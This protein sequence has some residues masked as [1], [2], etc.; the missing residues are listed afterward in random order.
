M[1]KSYSVGKNYPY[2]MSVCEAG[3]QF[4]FACS[5][6]GNLVLKVYNENGRLIHTINMLQYRVIGNVYS[7]IVSGLKYREISYEY[8]ADGRIVTDPY[9]MKSKK[10]HKWGDFEACID[11]DK[12]MLYVDDFDWEGDVPLKIPYNEVIGYLLHVRGFTKHPSSKV[13][14]KGTFLGIV[15][16]ITYLKELGIT[17]LVLMPAYDF[18]ECELFMDY[19]NISATD[20]PDFEGYSKKINY[21]GYKT[22][23]YFIPK[24]SYAYTDDPIFEFKTLVKMLHRAGIEVVMQFYFAPEVR[25][26]LILRCLKFWAYEYHIDGFHI[27]G[28]DLPIDLIAT[29]PSLTEVKIYYHYYELGKIVNSENDF[30]NDKLAVYNNDY[31]NDMRKMLKSDEDMIPSFLFRMRSNSSTLK[32]INYITSYEGFTLN[33][34]VSYD[35]KH[36]EL[37]GEENRDGTSY[38]FSW[39][40]GVEGS[41]RKTQILKLRMKQMKNAITMLMFSQ[42]VPMLLSGDELMNSAKGNN[43]PYCQDNEI[44]WINW[45][46]NKSNNEFYDF[47]SSLITIRKKHPILHPVSEFRLLDSKATGYP[48]L[49]YHGENAWYPNLD[50]HIRHVGIMLCG[51]YATDAKGEKDSF[52]YLA[53]NMHWEEHSFALPRLPKKKRWHFL[54]TTEA[55]SEKKYID[56]IKVDSVEQVNVTPRT[57]VVFEGY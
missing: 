47:V 11:P 24:S 44:T 49:S 17:Q 16:K 29:E 13:K 37:N 2:G 51:D 33:D 30:I 52:F 36:N 46:K 23:N 45:K 56:E 3:V 5:A 35:Y 53:V 38:N 14:S 27:L 18:E 6:V 28:A 4:C 54:L 15:E 10:H 20:N 1:K 43:N 12:A 42:G 19:R 7:V 55:G 57:I 9:M 21:W 22:G 8:V 34:L 25:K 41:T 39:N 26:T 31:L 40:C 50:T 32:T 48:D